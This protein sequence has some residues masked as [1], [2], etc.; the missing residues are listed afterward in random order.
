[1]VGLPASIL[2]LNQLEE[3][4]LYNNKLKELPAE[5][6]YLK[7]LRELYVYGNPLN[8]DAIRSVLKLKKKGMRTDIAGEYNYNW[9]DN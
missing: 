7:E 5:I 6:G 9:M 8:V 3:L 2:K 1:M 4:H